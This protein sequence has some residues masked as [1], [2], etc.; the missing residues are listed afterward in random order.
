[1]PAP[2]SRDLRERLLNWY[3][4]GHGTVEQAAVHFVVGP[5]TAERWVS[6]CRATGERGPRP[7][8]GA[9]SAP[10]LNAEALEQVRRLVLE[11][12]SR[13]VEELIDLLIEGGGPSV[14]PSTLK[15]GLQKLGL[16]RKKTR[17][18]S[19]RSRARG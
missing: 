12:P 19:K 9:R 6:R 4:A 10:K 5:A 8:G 14:S 3:F 16:T 11:E 17:P 18:A 7:M 1:M 13:T 15:R 2:Y